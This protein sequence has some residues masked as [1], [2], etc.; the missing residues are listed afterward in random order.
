M[1]CLFGNRYILKLFLKDFIRPIFLTDLELPM[2][3]KYLK[4]S[5]F[6]QKYQAAFL[7]CKTAPNNVIQIELSN[8]G[9]VEFSIVIEPHFIFKC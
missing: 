9:I 6:V 7:S 2:Q 3:D 1:R 5:I 4:A 8:K